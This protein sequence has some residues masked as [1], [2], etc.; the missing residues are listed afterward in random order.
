MGQISMKISALPGSVLS[1][2]QQIC[3]IISFRMSTTGLG[4]TGRATL[5][6]MVGKV[7]N[8]T[9]FPSQFKAYSKT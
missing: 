6:L 9:G 8:P 4:S 5:L 1:E 2:N 7:F 3:I